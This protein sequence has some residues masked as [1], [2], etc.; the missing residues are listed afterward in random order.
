MA[1][2][3][4]KT[5]Q[6]S[7]P[8]YLVKN[9]LINYYLVA[10]FG[11]FP[12]YFSNQ[13]SNI[14]HDKYNIFL[15][16]TSMLIIVELV[17]FLSSYTNSNK[18]E[19]DKKWYQTLSV[20]DICMIAFILFCF[21]STILSEHPA[22]A[23][24]GNMGRNNGLILMVLYVAVYFA[25]TRL[26][27]FYE[28]VFLALAIGTGLVCFLAIIN[29]CYIDPLNM[30]VGYAERYVIDFSSTI[31]NKNLL[32]SY[33]CVCLPV[34]M[35][36]F[37]NTSNKNFK[38][39]YY[40][41]MILGFCTLIVANSDSGYLGFFAFLIILLIYYIRKPKMLYMYFFSLFSMFIGA[42]LLR[43]FSLIMQDHNK[44]LSLI[45]SFFVYENFYSFILIIACGLL[46]LLFF[47]ISNKNPNL[48]FHRAVFWI[49][50]SL[51]LMGVGVITY[52]FILYTFI[53]TKT[54]FEH[55]SVLNYFRFNER[56]GT[57]RGYMWIRT[58]EIF[59]SFNLK[60]M[61]FGCGPDN[62]YYAFSPYFNEL[63]SLYGDGSTNCAHNEYLNYL[64]T[65]GILGLTA[66]LGII[67]GTIVRAVK[68]A[69]V[70]PFAMICC[71]GVICYAIQAIVNIAQP[72][73]TPIFILMICLTEAFCKLTKKEKIIN[74]SNI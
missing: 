8:K 65:N 16:F 28:Y 15:L 62:F 52:T 38:W 1:N 47:Y 66:Y 57:H 72:I 61:L 31:G 59:S 44:G 32:A 55:D 23:V 19:A 42:K 20:P 21:I 41:S 67:I 37:M 69:R 14:R 5:K 40:A 18:L 34:L 25:I 48:I 68:Y 3:S 27:M 22:E 71:A 43:L 17:I 11:F 73:T 39:V 2:S 63:S 49:A 12:L 54:V 64:V 33:I 26:Y 29:F 60:D 30:F 6:N 9:A 36:L 51:C 10:M 58:M 70:N 46:A 35:M 13:Y 50:L 45:P 56:W 4:A 74:H 24:T 53:D 7:K